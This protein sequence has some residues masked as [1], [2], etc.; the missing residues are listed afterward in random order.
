MSILSSS[1]STFCGNRTNASLG[2]M[3]GLAAT[4]LYHCNAVVGGGQGLR[5][6]VT[7]SCMWSRRCLAAADCTF[8]IREDPGV[9]PRATSPQCIRCSRRIHDARIRIPTRIRINTVCVVERFLPRE[10][11]RNY[12]LGTCSHLIFERLKMSKS[13]ASTRTG[14]QRKRQQVK[15]EKTSDHRETRTRHQPRN[16]TRIRCLLRNPLSTRRTQPSIPSLHRR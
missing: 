4:G 5:V 9:L 2:A 13:S 6:F 11:D 15:L 8:Q 14:A 1:T 10:R 16:R 3:S 12:S 7:C